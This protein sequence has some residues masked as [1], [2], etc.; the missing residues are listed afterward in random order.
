MREKMKR[1]NLERDRR[2]TEG[3]REAKIEV[4]VK[5][6]SKRDSEEE[7]GRKG[8]REDCSSPRE[9]DPRVPMLGCVEPPSWPP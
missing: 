2:Q 4:E 8:R 9:G 5:T 3:N 7:R 1:D 6:E